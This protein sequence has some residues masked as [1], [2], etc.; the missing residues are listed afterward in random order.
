MASDYG[1]LG[2]LYLARSDLDKAEEM[3]LK[4]LEIEKA[5]G[6]REGMASQYGN[7][8]A[9]HYARGQVD[10]ARERWIRARDLYAD[11][12]MPHM[13]E[14]VQGWIDGLDR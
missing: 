3:H 10:K 14:K 6:R 9:V 12:G 13:V 7:L 5:L 11:I 4:S 1:G 2:N 8:G